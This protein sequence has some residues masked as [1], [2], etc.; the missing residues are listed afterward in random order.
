[1]TMNTIKLTSN[2]IR[3]MVNEAV[4]RTLAAK[5]LNEGWYPSRGH[6]YYGIYRENDGP[7]Y[8]LRQ[9]RKTS[10]YNPYPTY[11]TFWGGRMTPKWYKDNGEKAGFDEEQ[12]KASILEDVEDFKFGMEKVLGKVEKLKAWAAK[13][14]VGLRGFETAFKNNV[15]FGKNGKIDKA[16]YSGREE[17]ELYINAKKA[18]TNRYSWD[19]VDEY[20]E[21]TP[22]ERDAD[23]QK[24]LVPALE[25]MY[26]GEYEEYTGDYDKAIARR[27]EIEGSV[28]EFLEKYG[29]ADPSQMSYVEILQAMNDVNEYI[30]KNDVYNDEAKAFFQEKGVDFREFRSRLGA[31]FK[32]RHDSVPHFYFCANTTDTP[33]GKARYDAQMKE[34]QELKAR[35]NAHSLE[36]RE[37]HASYGESIR[38]FNWSTGELVDDNGELV[39]TVK[40]EVDSSD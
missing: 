16:L 11:D 24:Y 29:D 34:Y 33:E 25:A 8:D 19:I 32:K 31:E 5:T 20:G 17:V 21:M 3:L 9:G 14:N 28:A 38:G 7:M 13:K 12:M 39:C 4:K 10:R 36:G 27:G 22:E 6:S 18:E 30:D 15:G 40:F 35:T 37:R 26:R 1:M 23:I 2:D